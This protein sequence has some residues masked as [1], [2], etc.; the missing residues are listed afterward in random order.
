MKTL[1]TAEVEFRIEFVEFIPDKLE[2]RVL[3]ISTEF[4]TASHKCPCGCGLE[5]VTPLSP[6]RWKLI[7]DGS[8]SLDP[9]IGNWSF[10]CRSH[11]WI[12]G[13]KAV[14]APQWSQERIS[15]NREDEA[16]QRDRYVRSGHQ[17]ISETRKS[18]SKLR[19]WKRIKRKLF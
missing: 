1:L 9:S 12:E 3:Y 14:W 10:P 7:F 4:K 16:S 8:V 11:Y 5:V 6:I 18:Q 2:D 13:N 15:I 19:W 17:K